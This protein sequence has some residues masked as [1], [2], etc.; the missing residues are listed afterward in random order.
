MLVA[1]DKPFEFMRHVNK[2]CYDAV[3]KVKEEGIVKS[4]A[5]VWLV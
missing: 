2:M 3:L 4:A 5:G 1:V